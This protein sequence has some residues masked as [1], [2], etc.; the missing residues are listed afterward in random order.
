MP[1]NPMAARAV[2]SF[3]KLRRAG[4]CSAGPPLEQSI[5]LISRLATAW[6]PGE[7]KFTDTYR[8]AGGD[9]RYELF[10]NSEHE[11]TGKPG[12]QTNRAYEMVRGF[13]ARNVSS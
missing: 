3:R 7:R 4:G 8:A 1:G 10:E 12:P 6:R 11:W 5:A 2:I 13:I 9:C